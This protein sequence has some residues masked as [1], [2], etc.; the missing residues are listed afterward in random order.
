[1]DD[2]QTYRAQNVRKLLDNDAANHEHIKCL[3]TLG[4]GEYDEII[5]YNELSAIVQDQHTR[6]MEDPDSA[7]SFLEIKGHVGLLLQKHP[8]YKCSAYNVLVHWEDGSETYEP[9]DIMVKDEPV[10]LAQYAKDNDFLSLPGWKR[11]RRITKN[12]KKLKR[13]LKQ[14]RLSQSRQRKGP[15]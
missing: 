1:M 3:V 2:G 13:M 8:D 15:I 9:L 5:T 11:L 12:E 4:E 10:T 14:A 7:W 6:E